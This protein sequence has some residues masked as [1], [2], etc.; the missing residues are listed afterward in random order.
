MVYGHRTGRGSAAPR[1]LAPLKE[2]VLLRLTAPLAVVALALVLALGPLAPAGRTEVGAPG[3]ADAEPVEV[4]IKPA[5]GSGLLGAVGLDVAALPGV[6]EVLRVIEP[7]GVHV[8]TVAPGTAE[9]VAARLEALPTVSYAEPNIAYEL[10]DEPDDPELDR[11]YALERIDAVAGWARYREAR[12]QDGFPA[13][14]GATLAVIDSGVD[15]LLHPEFADK[16]AECR[17]WMAGVN[18]DVCQDNNVHGTHVA[19]IAAAIADNGTGI[20]GV[21]FDAEIM[22][23]QTCTLTCALADVAEALIFAAENDADVV[24]MSFGGPESDTLREAVAHA[25]EAGVLPVAASGNDGEEVNFPAAYEEV[26]A[27]SATDENDEF[28]TFSS[29]GPEIDVAAPGVG[30][31][32]TVPTGLLHA[33][34]SGTSQSAPHVAGLAALLTALDPEATPDEVRAAITAGAEPIPGASSDEQG[35]GRIDVAESIERF[36]AR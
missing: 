26:M 27:V 11:Q 9:R 15:E 3:P 16:I 28:A 32:S 22:A 7:L 18:L 21:G 14:G 1:P 5:G 34:L 4:L 31:L 6:G 36:L 25:A 12:G 10:L 30:V 2:V 8:A 17:S 13:T 20:A 23:L 24:N 33:E 19:G 29:H 35:A